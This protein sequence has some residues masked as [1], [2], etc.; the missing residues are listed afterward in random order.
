MSNKDQRS[1]KNKLN[2]DMHIYGR[3]FQFNNHVRSTKKL[4]I[5]KKS[6]VNR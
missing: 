4:D 2:D 1:W 6:R 5:K 3:N